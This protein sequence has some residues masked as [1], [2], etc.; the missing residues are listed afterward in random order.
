MPSDAPRYAPIRRLGAYLV[1]VVAVTAWEVVA[2]FVGGW[3]AVLG[4][5]LAVIFTAAFMAVVW[6]LVEI[7]ER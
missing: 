4:L 3:P 1:L 2:F 6:A 7:L 5:P